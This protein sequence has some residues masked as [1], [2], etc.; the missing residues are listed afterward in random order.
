MSVEICGQCKTPIFAH[1]ELCQQYYPLDNVV[2][3]FHHGKCCYYP[4]T[5]EPNSN[6]RYAPPERLKVET[7]TTQTELSRDEQIRIAA[8]TN[9]VNHLQNYVTKEAF[10]QCLE[11]FESYIRGDKMSDK[12]NG[13]VFLIGRNYAVCQELA[14]SNATRHGRRAIYITPSTLHLVRGYKVLPGDEVYWDLYDLDYSF[15]K[16]VMETLETED[17]TVFKKED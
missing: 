7:I 14:G 4:S 3:S 9:A 1:Q 15:I 13:R 11:D 12:G 10:H 6:A 8:L 17:P 16:A 2:T 5:H